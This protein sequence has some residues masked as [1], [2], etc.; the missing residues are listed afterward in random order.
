VDE[1]KATNRTL[2]F[3]IEAVLL[4]EPLPESVLYDSQV[5]VLTRSF[6]IQI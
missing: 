5:D 2:H 1:R 4:T 6:R 3:R